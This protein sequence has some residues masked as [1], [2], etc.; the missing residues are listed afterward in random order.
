MVH[1]I[2]P[3]LYS[4]YLPC[5]RLPSLSS[6]VLDHRRQCPKS[7]K[8]FLVCP[9]LVVL[10]ELF[11]L[12]PLLI[13][14]GSFICPSSSSFNSGFSHQQ[15]TSSWRSPR[16][17]QNSPFLY[18]ATSRPPTWRRQKLSPRDYSLRSCY[19]CDVVCRAVLLL[20]ILRYNTTYFGLLCGSRSLSCR[21]AL[22]VCTIKLTFCFVRRLLS[23][24]VRSTTLCYPF[25]LCP[26][27]RVFQQ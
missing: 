17:Q 23:A 10:A 6:F 14:L 19:Y 24:A 13:L 16:Q 7:T 11:T 27:A 15:A 18:S 4:R 12:S 26:R 25:V 1:Y 5:R 2:R 3:P 9:R 20:D 8:A 22:H 21:E